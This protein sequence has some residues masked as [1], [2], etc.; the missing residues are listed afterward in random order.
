M[1]APNQPS[2]T[3]QTKAP[4][5]TG[6][7]AAIA[8]IVV[9]VVIVA[10]LYAAGYLTPKSTKTTANACVSAD[11]LGAGSTLVAPLMDVWEIAY[12]TSS[13]NYE[14]VGSSAGISQITAKT[15]DFGASD[16]PLNSTQRAAIPGVLEIPESAGAVAIIYHIPGIT[17]TINFTGTILA[18]IYLGLLTNWNTSGLQAINP[19]IT[20]P[21]QPISVVH[22][23]DG[24]GT[25]FAFT[26]F[27]SHDNATWATKYGKTTLPTWPVGTGGKGN[28][29]VAGDVEDISYSIG[30][31]D[32]VYALN[33]GITIG[34][35]ENPM[36]HF[37]KASLAAAT[38]A[39]ADAAP[40]ANAGNPLPAGSQS[41]YNVSLVNANG[42]GDYPIVTFTYVMVYTALDTAYAGSGNPYTLQKAEDLVNWLHWMVNATEGQTYSPAV[43]YVVLPASVLTLDETTI[44][45]ITYGGSAVP[46]CS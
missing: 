45:A 19:G 2:E 7:Y 18:G 31:V 36:A 28:S 13:V 42:A 35:V 6:L 3:I 32:L 23:S 16:A 20:F 29:G 4:S 8:V 9:I 44:A 25:S 10:G 39:L 38:T 46:T 37:V 1:S 21:N 12:K 34:A 40:T 26:D 30:Y 22:R 14:S 11:L 27:L 17:Q 41:W 33:A 24:S 43:D 5:R 15:V